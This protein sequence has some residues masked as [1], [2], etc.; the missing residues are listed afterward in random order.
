MYAAYQQELL[1]I[2]E[3]QKR[4]AVASYARG[5]SQAANTK[6]GYIYHVRVSLLE[7]YNF[8][9]FDKLMQKWSKAA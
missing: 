7:K 6:K 5:S 8:E 9:K 4:Q 1:D 2:F 3:A